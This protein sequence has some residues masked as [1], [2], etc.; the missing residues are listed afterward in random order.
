MPSPT[1]TQYLEGTEVTQAEYDNAVRMVRIYAKRWFRSLTPRPTLGFD[2]IEHEAEVATFKAARRFQREQ[3]FAFNSYALTYGFG[4]VRQFVT[5]WARGHLPRKRWEHYGWLLK[6]GQFEVDALPPWDNAAWSLEHPVSINNGCDGEALR[7]KD[8][9]CAP[10][11]FEDEITTRDA[12][13]S[14][15]GKLRPKH[16]QAMRRVY[17]DGKS[18]EE[19]AAELGVTR[20]A[21]N[22]NLQ[23]GRAKFRELY[24][25]L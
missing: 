19:V 9:I 3:G 18:T 6:R 22:V 4:A 2:E 12:V 10:G 8:M 14:V 7:L 16:A 17:L 20:Q 15:L 5:D 25:E 11:R 21:V 23:R 13:Q 1:S 24:G